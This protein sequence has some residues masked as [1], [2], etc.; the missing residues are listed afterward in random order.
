MRSRKQRITRKKQNIGLPHTDLLK[1]QR[2]HTQAIKQEDQGTFKTTCG[3]SCE[4]TQT[5]QAHEVTE[6]S[7]KGDV[8]DIGRSSKARQLHSTFNPSGMGRPQTSEDVTEPKESDASQYNA[9]DALI[10]SYP[11]PKRHTRLV[12][13]HFEHSWIQPT[14]PPHM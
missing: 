10:M 9:H 11:T 7:S 3:K 5:Q 1:S 13:E 4:P 12:G 6:E 8:Q 14:E 2:P